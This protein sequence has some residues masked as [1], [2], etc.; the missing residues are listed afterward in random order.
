MKRPKLEF[1]HHLESEKQF[2]GCE[3]RLPYEADRHAYETS[4]RMEWVVDQDCEDCESISTCHRHV[5]VN[6]LNDT[7]VVFGNVDHF[8]LRL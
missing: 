4:R 3:T 2:L 8:V 6:L 1:C 7:Q 5:E